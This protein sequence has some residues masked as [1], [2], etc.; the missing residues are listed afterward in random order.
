MLIDGYAIVPNAESANSAQGWIGVEVVN[1]NIVGSPLIP[2][3]G[4][5]TA[6]WLLLDWAYVQQRSSVIAG[7]DQM[8][9]V[10]FRYDIRAQRRMRSPQDRLVIVLANDPG[11]LG[12]IRMQAFV[13]SLWKL[14]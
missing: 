12:N 13:R 11:S 7:Y 8:S 5:D 9:S 1:E 14:P 10:R 3:P 4:T 2:V 6:D